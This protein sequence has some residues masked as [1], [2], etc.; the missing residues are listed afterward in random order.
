MTRL[1]IKLFIRDYENVK[2]YSVR[3]K[4][5]FLS[6]LVGI[7]CNLILFT[8]KFIIGIISSSVAV[9]ADAFNN[10]SDASSSIV[11][12]I[13]FKMASKPADKDHPFGHGRIE[14][15]TGLIVS[16]AIILMGMELAKSSIENIFHAEEIT[17]N[18]FS[19]CILI[20]S[21]VIKLWLF[22]FN[23]AISKKIDSTVMK[24][25]AIDS[26]SDV[27]ATLT[28]IVSVLI[29][30][31][32]G[33]N[34]D[35]F[36]GILVSIFIIW[37]GISTA[38]ETIKPLVG[39]SPDKKILNLIEEKVLSYEGVLGVHDILIHNYG[40]TKIVASLHVETLDNITLLQAHSIADKIEKDLNKKFNGIFL[41]H[42][43]PISEDKERQI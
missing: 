17:F 18:K 41:V 40:P 12:L 24:A 10:L 37:T 2:D 36:A 13:G 16:L 29:S 26:L 15:I 33:L 5:G 21:I 32:T 23:N 35:G 28:V 1:L 11:T 3:R 4:Y 34:I 20:G 38:K 27:I 9:M 39:T 6:G 19:L 30:R 8:S 43:D 31:S 25:S 14:Y 42:V 7:I 22:V